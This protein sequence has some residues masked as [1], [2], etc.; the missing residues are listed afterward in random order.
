MISDWPEKIREQYN[1][2]LIAAAGLGVTKRS[3]DPIALIPPDEI[4]AKDLEIKF[5]DDNRPELK[6]DY[7]D[8]RSILQNE[9]K[10][11]IETNN[12]RIVANNVEKIAIEDQYHT[13]VLERRSNVEVQW[14]A[15]RTVRNK[16][17]AG[18]DWTQLLDVA[19]DKQFKEYRQALRDITEY[20]TVDDIV[21]PLPPE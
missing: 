21:W 1:F 7:L 2:A 9:L 11:M 19:V 20:E 15:V 16:L 18:Y 8:Q 13:E 5:L 14:T 6:S 10:T 4:D 12:E 17:I 3:Y